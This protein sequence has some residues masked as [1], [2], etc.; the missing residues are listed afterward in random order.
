MNV[1]GPLIIGSRPRLRCSFF[2]LDSGTATP[3]DPTTVTVTVQT[4]AGVSTTY[5]L[6]DGDIERD[7][8]GVYSID[9]TMS[10]AGTW[11]VRWVGGGSLVAPAE[12]AVVV[13]A[14]ALT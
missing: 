11:L 6:V 7:S 4:P 10:E 9:V 1:D 14:S 3:A 5:A 12:S 8:T 2:S 13:T